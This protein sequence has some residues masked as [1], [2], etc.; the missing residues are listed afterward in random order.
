MRQQGATALQEER[1]GPSHVY[2]FIYSEAKSWYKVEAGPES[3]SSC[4]SLLSPGMI[5]T[6]AK[7]TAFEG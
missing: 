6:L 3:Q 7:I 2:V 1:D 4:L 5:G